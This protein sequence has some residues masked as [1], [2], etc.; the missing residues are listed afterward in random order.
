MFLKKTGHLLHLFYV[1][2]LLAVTTWVSCLFQVLQP[3]DKKNR[4]NVGRKEKRTGEKIPND[5]IEGFAS[6]TSI[7]RNA[8][9]YPKKRKKWEWGRPKFFR[10]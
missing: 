5:K 3:V 6:L 4:Q 10:R 2:Y 9:Q 8:V 1:L 7:Y